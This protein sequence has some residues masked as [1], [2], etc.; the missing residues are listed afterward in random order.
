MKEITGSVPPLTID[1]CD[2]Q[3]LKKNVTK[4]SIKI[5]EGRIPNS[6]RSGFQQFF[7]FQGAF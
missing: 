7:N 5:T 4:K 1:V 2:R 3:V 6:F